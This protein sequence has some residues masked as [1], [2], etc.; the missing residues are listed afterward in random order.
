MT[1][2]VLC[3]VTGG[4]NAADPEDEI[5]RYREM[6]DDPMANPAYLNVDRGEALW[7]LPRGEKNA[8]LATCDLGKGPGTLEG[9]Y[10]EL[11]RYFADADKVM[12]LEQRLLWCM[13][14]VQALDTHDVLSRK[15]GAPG[16]TSDMEDLVAYIANKSS[17]MTYHIPLDD[18]QERDAY[19]IGEELFYRRGSLLDFSCATC[20]SAD[21][22]RIRTTQLPNLTKPG[23]D[24]RNT[25]GSWP[26]YRVSQSQMRTMQNRLWDCYRQMRM[27]PPDYGSAGLTALMIYLAKQADGGSIN[28][29][30]I[31]R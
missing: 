17:G 9:A 6:I 7:N 16:S 29:P 1:L 8:S 19:A 28:V 24:A 18:V 13:E 22:A 15:F 12:D 30:S 25:M 3:W 4:L 14:T 10:A 23:G 26:T 27:P 11:P 31:K 21:G 2:G 5:R 20:H